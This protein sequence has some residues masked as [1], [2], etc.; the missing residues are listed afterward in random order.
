MKTLAVILALT[1]LVSAPGYADSLFTKT[2]AQKGTLI[3]KN[4]LFKVGDIITVNVK[5]KIDSSAIADTN[6]KKE[7]DVQAEADAG[8]NT[9]LIAEK[10]D[11]FGITTAEKLPNWDLSGANETKAKGQIRRES[12]LNATVT[13]V[14]T[15]VLDNGLIAIEG[16]KMVNVS[17][18]QSK[19]H[20]SGLIRARDVTPANTVLSSQMA[21]ASIELTGKGPLW[22]TTRRG[23]VT[24]LLDWVNPF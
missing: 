24:R 21:N 6:T 15:A 23:V 13:C 2:A 22:N 18:E 10:P 3:A 9:F 4:N 7:S 20:V 12:E 14:V 16:E 19:L 8:D 5:E 11:G 17:R 1:A